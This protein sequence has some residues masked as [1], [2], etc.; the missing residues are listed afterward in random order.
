MAPTT[1]E[2]RMKDR[3]TTTGRHHPEA[4]QSNAAA[5][6]RTTTPD[7]ITSAGRGDRATIRYESADSDEVKALWAKFGRDKV[8]A[9]QGF[10]SMTLGQI[11]AALK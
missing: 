2:S 6:V 4:D 7:D 5:N 1:D 11:A 3:G 8:K 10:R 9:M